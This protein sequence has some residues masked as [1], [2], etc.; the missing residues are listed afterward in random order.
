MQRASQRIMAKV[1]NTM[2]INGEEFLGRL[3]PRTRIDLFLFYKECLMNIC[4]H[5]DATRFD[6]Q[7]T[8]SPKEIVLSISDNGKGL[9]EGT[10]PASLKRRAR[11]LKAKLTTEA[12][13]GGGTEITLRRR[14]GRKKQPMRS[15]R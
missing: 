8:A 4:R 12:H 2:K 7:L 15:E 10:L 5:S 1:E 13:P 14:N 9:P 3:K 6:T 11:L